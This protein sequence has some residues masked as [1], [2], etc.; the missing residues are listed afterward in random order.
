MDY[1]TKTRTAKTDKP[2]KRFESDFSGQFRS[3]GL[4]IERVLDLGWNPVVC[5]YYAVIDDGNCLGLPGGAYFLELLTT[6]EAELPLADVEPYIL[7]E[8]ARYDETL[9]EIHAGFLINFTGGKERRIVYI[10]GSNLKGYVESHPQASTLPNS[11]LDQVGIPMP[12]LKE[13]TRSRK[14]LKMDIP[15]F[16]LKIHEADLSKQND[17]DAAA[18]A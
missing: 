12:M 9:P 5:D 6:S 16:L 3:Y 18:A 14:C 2:S 11:V 15:S 10:S 7:T 1:G 8:L 13:G 4:P 17:N